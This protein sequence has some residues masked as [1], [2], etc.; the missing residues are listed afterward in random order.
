MLLLVDKAKPNFVLGYLIVLTEV[1]WTRQKEGEDEVDP[2]QM[3]EAKIQS[4]VVSLIGFLISM[5][6]LF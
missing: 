1:I 5:A 4:F 3:E 2:H 6:V